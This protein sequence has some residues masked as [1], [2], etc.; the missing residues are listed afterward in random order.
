MAE[1]S[2][3]DSDRHCP[4][5]VVTAEH[6]FLFD[7]GARSPLRIAQA[8]LPMDRI[9]GVFLTHFHSDHIAALY[10]FN[11]NSWVAGRA[12]PLMVMGP[13]GVDRVVEGMNAAYELDRGYRV[14]H[15]GAD[16]LPPELGVMEARVIEPGVVLDDD[17]LRI[18]AFAVDHAPV[19]PAVG[20][21]FDY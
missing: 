19:D 15:H 21:R 8:G 3:G 6:F 5:A 7:V 16:L 10:E 4:I 13:V 17:G 11:L 9:D 12:S 2:D 18:T 20:Y 14:T 1:T